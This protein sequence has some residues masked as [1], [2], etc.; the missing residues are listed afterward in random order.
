MAQVTQAQI[1]AE[2]NISRSTVAAVL[3]RQPTA[4]IS[5]E[6][7]KKILVTAKRMGYRP[8]RY[9]QT[10]RKG[11]SGLI[12]VI[13]FGGLQ[14]MPIQKLI[15]S[16]EAITRG[17]FEPFVQDVFWFTELDDSAC[18]K[19]ISLRVEGVLLMHPHLQ[20][21]QKYLDALLNAD[22]PVVSMGGEHLQGIP[23]F[24]SDKEGGFYTLTKHLISL[25]HKTLTLLLGKESPS[26]W[27]SAKSQLGFERAIHE[28]K[29]VKGQVEFSTYSSSLETKPLSPYQ[30]GYEAMKKLLQKP[31]LPQAVLCSN[32][33]W[34]LGALT[35]CGEAE[36]Q[37]PQQLA[38]TGFENEPF[39]EAGLLP[40]TTVAHPVKEIA[41]NAANLLIDLIRR[42]TM[43][44]SSITIIPGSLIVRRSCGSY[45][46]KHAR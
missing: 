17:G 35:A 15:H 23:R 2:L 22:I 46:K 13:N 30:P 27:H 9:A 36:I 19:M 25:G 10:I 40:L 37:V 45:L 21:I 14:Q 38:I 6:L 12:G 44:Q 24:M 4:Q 32:D 8:N 7:S 39:A 26:S 41:H 1:A 5:K 42:K 33:N 11:T 20:F 3:S 34:A 18:E 16:V 29:G 43:P 28:H 31:Q